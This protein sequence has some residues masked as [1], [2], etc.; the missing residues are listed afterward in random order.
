M[1]GGMMRVLR[2]T[3]S[4]VPSGPWRTTTLEASH[5]MGPR[6]TGPRAP[7]RAPAP[8][9]VGPPVQPV[10]A[11]QEAGGVVVWSGS[12]GHVSDM[13]YVMRIIVAQS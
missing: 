2:P 11:G 5:T 1:A 9:Q 13:V 10:G 12:L 3:F 4:T 7:S 6:A 8:D